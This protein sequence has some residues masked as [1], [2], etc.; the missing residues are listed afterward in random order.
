MKKAIA[1]LFLSLLFFVSVPSVS[2]Q[3]YDSYV[4]QLPTPA[5]VTAQTE[6]ARQELERVV[7]EMLAAGHMAPTTYTIGIG[8]SGLVYFAT[9]PEVIYTLSITYPYLSSGLQTQLRSYLQSE[10][11]NYPPVTLAGYEPN[12]GVVNP[13]S[14]A[15]TRREYYPPNPQK[16]INIWPAPRVHPWVNYALWAYAYY[17]GDWNYVQSRY[18]QLKSLY[19]GVANSVDDYAELAGVI[20]FA[21]IA[22]HLG[23]TSDYQAALTSANQAFAAASNFNQFLANSAAKF[24]RQDHEY[25]LPLLRVDLQSDTKVRTFHFN[26]DIGRF[27]RDYAQA[28]AVSYADNKV[29]KDMPLCWLTASSMT[30]GENLFATPEISW[31]YMMLKS[32]VG[33]ES[34]QSLIKK[35][36]KPDR[37]GDLYYIQKLVA[38]LDTNDGSEVT[39]TPTPSPVCR[40]DVNKNGRVEIGDISG[41][42][43]YWGQSCTGLGQVCQADVNTN[44]KVEIGDI[45]GVL[46]Y[47]GG[48]CK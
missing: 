9:P 23:N 16:A 11:Q 29:C 10:L 45:A 15:G 24:P 28:Q 41:I 42:L 27:L 22:S 21:R 48:E 47:W 8:G 26:R 17:T 18:S 1:T 2:A 7:Q 12:W 32:Y 38:I 6:P 35:L 37:K 34:T 5:P 20:G 46:F 3:Q 25:V 14:W 4:T 13:T 36:D 44:G 30:H 19:Q 33:G 43:F 39:A 40:A 31:H